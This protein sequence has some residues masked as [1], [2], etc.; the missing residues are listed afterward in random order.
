MSDVHLRAMTPADLPAFDELCRLAGW[1]QTAADLQRML[2]VC[3]QGM[4]SAECEGRLCGSASAISYGSTCGWIGMILV[5][6]DF[7]RRGIA[8]L[9]MS[10]CIDHLRGL[11]VRSIMLDATDQ[12]RPVYQKLG[13]ID[14]QP[15]VRLAG[16]GIDPSERPGNG[17]TIRPIR[18]D[19]LE[20][21]AALDGPV[22]GAD[23]S[24]LLESLANS[25]PAMLARRDG[26]L[27]AFGMARGGHN[28]AF[29]GPVTAE[30]A[31]GASQ[32][33]SALL[34][35]LGPDSDVYWDLLPDNAVASEL[36]AEL[37]FA[38]ARQ[39]TRMYLGQPG[40]G[41]AG[42]TYAIAGFEWG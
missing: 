1:N 36:A 17:L 42:R 24:A 20:A 27:V 30:H 16:C 6:P 37:G 41:D 12:G 10:Q 33:V 22:F 40:P 34:A 38:T 18:Q 25:G 2:D 7:R 3:P 15:V 4:F 19:D 31:D 23:R 29:M 32:I 14:E 11:G 39:L 26:R 9:L 13:F 5:H 8:T 21:I 28:A 35:E